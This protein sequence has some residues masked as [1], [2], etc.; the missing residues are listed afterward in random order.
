[1]NHPS[2]RSTGLALLLAATFGLAGVAVAQD[3]PEGQSCGGL[4][5]D[6][7]L[8]GHKVAPKPAAPAPVA[9]FPPSAPPK[10]SPTRISP[11]RSLARSEPRPDALAEPRQAAA[12][13]KTHVAKA[14]ATPAAADRP[15]AVAPLPAAPPSKASP[16]DA[17]LSKTSP[18]GAPPVAATLAPPPLEVK[19]PTSAVPLAPPVA[20][21]SSRSAIDAVLGPQPEAVSLTPVPA[22]LPAAAPAP[23]E[24]IVLA[25]PYV[26]TRPLRPRFQS[27]DPLVR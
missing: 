24:P 14:V 4:V 5:C 22:G 21:P 6:L 27:V 16:F 8:F 12:H 25:N 1:M 3:I 18:F 7:G 19:A 2:D 11:T 26:S 20:T 13:R 15:A 23:D 9:S 10:P 17:P